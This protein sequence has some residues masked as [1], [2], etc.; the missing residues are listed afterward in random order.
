M[1]SIYRP[2]VLEF[3]RKLQSSIFLFGTKAR[4]QEQKARVER[5]TKEEKKI[6]PR[7]QMVKKEDL[8]QHV[9]WARVHE[10]EFYERV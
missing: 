8:I 7:L 4:K 2:T 9:V 5:E 10:L 1:Q 6:D 3:Y